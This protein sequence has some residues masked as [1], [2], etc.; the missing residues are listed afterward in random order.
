[1]KKRFLAIFESEKGSFAE[2]EKSHELLI[3]CGSGGIEV[4]LLT[5]QS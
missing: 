1:V 3:M 2:R 4:I 5:W